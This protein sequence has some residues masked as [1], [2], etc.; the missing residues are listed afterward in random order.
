MPPSS[1]SISEPVAAGRPL[2]GT[3]LVWTGRLVLAFLLAAVLFEAYL[4]LPPFRSGVSPVVYDPVLGYWHKLDYQG[5]SFS[6][7]YAV[8]Y[9]FDGRGLRPSGGPAHQDGTPARQVVMLGDSQVEAVMVPDDQVMHR[10]L[11]AYLGDSVEVLNYGLAGSGADLQY[12]VLKNRVDLAATGWIVQLVNLDTDIYEADPRNEKPGERPRAQL[13]FSDLDHFRAIPPA[14]FG[15]GERL[16]EHAS[17]FQSYSYVRAA[18][19]PLRQAVRRVRQALGDRQAAIQA[20]APAAG[21]HGPS[22][23]G[24][25]NLL[26]AL[27]LTQR[28]AAEHG[29]AYLPVVWST[30]PTLFAE[31][32]RRSRAIGLPS[33]A[34]APALAAIG[35]DLSRVSF[36]CDRHFTAATHDKIAEALARSSFF[37]RDGG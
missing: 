26:G 15:W 7:C 37:T 33:F 14:P 25:T 22:E 34:L 12:L 6:R 31:W 23:L 2:I 1:T 24:W 20:E 36:P 9:S 30:D 21:R 5:E 13:A 10:R 11:Q 16:R 32:Q 17:D 3:I 29:I 28:L 27:H 4:R 18:L 8:P 35:V 19:V